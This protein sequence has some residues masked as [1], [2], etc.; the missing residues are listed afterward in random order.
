ME[1]T[2]ASW[3]T[4]VEQELCQAVDA[5]D[6]TTRVAHFEAAVAH[7]EAAGKPATEARNMLTAALFARLA[8]LD[9]V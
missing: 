5:S 7:L 9:D 1:V 6:A 8:F 3:S 4:R 2:Q